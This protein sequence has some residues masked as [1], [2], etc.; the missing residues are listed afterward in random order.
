MIYELHISGVDN[1]HYMI[2]TNDP[3]L[4]LKFLANYDHEGSSIFLTILKD[5]V[6]GVIRTIEEEINDNE[7]IYQRLEKDSW[8]EV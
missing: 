3:K 5:F 6:K 2:G 4:V 7:K 1:N 8:K